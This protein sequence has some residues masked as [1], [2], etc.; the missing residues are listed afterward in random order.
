MAK[1]PN[2]FDLNKTTE[3]KFDLGK[4]NERKFDLSKDNEATETIVQTST[5]T[6]HSQTQKNKKKWPIVI[7]VI[8]AIVLLVFG[9]TKFGGKPHSESI[10]T[11]EPIVEEASSADSTETPATPTI[12]NT[13]ESAPEPSAGTQD[14]P[15][16]SESSESQVPV[17]T[18]PPVIEEATVP[19]T[20]SAPQ[21]STSNDAPMT[22]SV[23]EKKALEVIR[24]DFG[25]GEERKQKLG[26]NYSVVQK[27]VNEMYAN[28]LVY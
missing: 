9:L 16:V 25:N 2:K 6:S 1:N 8:V 21:S 17:N 22:E 26:S 19:V 3:K 7:V 13:E 15:I 10:V 20:P 28:G 12:E 5:S 23:I 27:K 18:V 24:G 11:N 14:T 4:S